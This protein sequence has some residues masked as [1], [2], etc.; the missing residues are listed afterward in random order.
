MTANVAAPARTAWPEDRHW[1]A[2]PAS[3][4]LRRLDAP[5]TGLDRAEAAARL[6]RCGPNVL[7]TK[8]PP[9][10]LE[11]GLRQLK[12]PLIY[13]LLAAAVAAVALGD[14]GDAAFIGL[15]LLIN[16]GVGG[17]QEWH[18]EQQSQGLQKLLLIRATALR[19]GDAVELDSAEL[20]PGDVVALESGRR[21]P[22]D[23]RL[24]DA[25]SLEI[26]EALLTGESLA[27][28]KD[29]AWTG[30]RRRGAG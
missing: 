27:V 12:S 9:G 21:V 28:L 4:V 1:H 3:E 23:L 6:E 16:S 22:A 13:V 19:D 17:W 7:P 30:S 25:H 8:P 24:L 15:V 18:A 26:E 2:L 11:I 29:A 10:V 14:L 5:A 20:V